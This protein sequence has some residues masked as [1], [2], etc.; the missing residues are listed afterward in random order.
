MIRQAG[1]RSLL[2]GARMVLVAAGCI[3]LSLAAPV[4]TVAST[5]PEP[6]LPGCDFPAS[7]VRAGEALEL[8]GSRTTT[9]PV[10]LTVVRVDNRDKRAIDAATVGSTW[11]AVLVFG[12]ADRGAWT[13][14]LVVDGAECASP[15]T[16]TLPDGVL[17]VET[18]APIPGPDESE[19][20]M[21]NGTIWTAL[22][23]GVAGTVLASWL[24]MLTF[25][26]SA[27]ARKS[28]G[29]TIRWVARG[30]AFISVI[31]AC[32]F[33]AL[34]AWFYV[35]IVHFDTGIP[36]DQEA[37]LNGGLWLA[38]IL[39]SILGTLAATR[40]RVA[41]PPSLPGPSL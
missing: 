1:V 27:R 18:A 13:I 34:A 12:A 20:V 21:D 9:E 24:F 8:S 3:A 26:A 7:T 31:G 25:M 38:G 37:L 22:W 10:G 41:R 15:L 35:G 33:V 14:D 17:P 40:I 30:S 28:A 5:Y 4:S 29:R 2:S 36:P 19:S 39:G 32:Y 16:V 23:L 6:S 11:H